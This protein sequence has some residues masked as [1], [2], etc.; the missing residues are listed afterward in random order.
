MRLVNAS[1]DYTYSPAHQDKPSVSSYSGTTDQK[2]G[3]VSITNGAGGRRRFLPP[4]LSGCFWHMD[5]EKVALFSSTALSAGRT[6]RAV[7]SP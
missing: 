3:T 7:A 5:A 6:L 1:T 4:R 2:L